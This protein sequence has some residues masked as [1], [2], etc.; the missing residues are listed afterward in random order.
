MLQEIAINGDFSF[1]KNLNELDSV[2]QRYSNSVAAVYDLVY[3]T[4]NAKLSNPID[5]RFLFNTTQISP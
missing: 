1:P 5:Y 2:F 3:E 4:N